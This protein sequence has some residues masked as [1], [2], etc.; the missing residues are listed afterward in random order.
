M[1]QDGD[2]DVSLGPAREIDPGGRPIFDGSLETPNRIVVVTTAESE[3]LL[4]AAVPS[5]STRVRIWT[6][7]PSE[8]DKIA[9]GLG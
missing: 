6:N 8:P 5:K 3:I 7:H 9:V 4:K 2:T 1:F